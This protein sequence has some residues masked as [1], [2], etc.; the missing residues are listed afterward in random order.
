MPG[1]V[2]AIRGGEE[3][4]LTIDKAIQLANEMHLPLYFLYV[5]NL[6]FLIHAMTGHITSVRGEMFDMG[7]FILAQAAEEAEKQG[8][9]AQ[10]VVREGKVA[11]EIITLSNEQQAQ[12][13]VI[14]RPIHEKDDNV[15]TMSHF[16]AF[17]KRLEDETGA[18][19]IA[20][21]E[22]TAEEDRA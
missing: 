3:S 5:V 18:R 10:G 2:C 12:Y 11:D 21:G 14:G 13:I 15:F 9:E 16:Q 4:Q 22:N 6:D 19:V 17:V 1:I 7:E 20:T 8:V